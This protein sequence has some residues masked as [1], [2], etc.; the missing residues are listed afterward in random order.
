MPRRRAPSISAGSTCAVR[1]LPPTFRPSPPESP[2]AL[3]DDAP[4]KALRAGLA[5]SIKPVP[6]RRRFCWNGS[7]PKKPTRLSPPPVAIA[8][9]A[10]DCGCAPPP[11]EPPE[12]CR[13]DLRRLSRSDVALTSPLS[14]VRSPDP[15]LSPPPTGD[16]RLK[17]ERGARPDGRCPPSRRHANENATSPHHAQKGPK[18]SGS[19]CRQIP[20]RMAFAQMALLRG[21]ASTPRMSAGVKYFASSSALCLRAIAPIVA[22]RAQLRCDARCRIT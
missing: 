2:I 6:L 21:R 20:G 4:P 15:C 22:S 14:V 3:A 9:T 13:R 1:P 11:P 12:A 19:N 18:T 8:N 7:C 17:T 5:P 10:A 16:I